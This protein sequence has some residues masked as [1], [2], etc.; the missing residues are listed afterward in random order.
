VSPKVVDKKARRRDILD[1]AM[2]IV[3]KRGMHDVTM[4]D[5]ARAAGVGKATV[6]EY[7]SGKQEIYAEIIHEYLDSASTAAA[8]EMFGARTPR[9]KL[10]ALLGAW[11]RTTVSESDDLIMLFLDVW[12]EAIRGTSRGSEDAMHLRSVFQ[13]YREFVAAI[14]QEGIDAGDLRPMDTMTV[15]S[16]LLATF[17]GVLLQWLLDR[18]SIDVEKTIDAVLDVIWNGIRAA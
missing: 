5:I 15:A 6:Y 11:L 1:A 9:E 16:S 3:A 7:F 13:E 14:L 4:S 8:K 2:R 12:T 18:E 17:D 10:S